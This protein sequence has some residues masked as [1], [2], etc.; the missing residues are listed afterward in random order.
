MAESVLGTPSQPGPMIELP[1]SRLDHF[2]DEWL[3]LTNP[4]TMDPSERAPVMS[5][6][7]FCFSG[8]CILMGLA[9]GI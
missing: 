8:I 9:F 6:F 1:V 4:K 3:H 2:I 5:S 7:L